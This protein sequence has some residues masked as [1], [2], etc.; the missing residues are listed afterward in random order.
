MQ[1]SLKPERQKFIQEQIAS[2]KF[3]EVE[4]V[5]DIALQILEKLNADYAQWIEETRE[6]VDVAIAELERGEGLD[7]ET[8]VMEILEKFRKAREE[9]E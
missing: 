7:G 5:V 4:E 9:K 1:I 3:T 8:F 2:G 6:K